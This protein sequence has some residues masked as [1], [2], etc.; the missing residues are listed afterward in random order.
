MYAD[1][2]STIF[3]GDSRYSKTVS[4]LHLTLSKLLV[5]LPDL[6]NSISHYIENSHKKSRPRFSTSFTKTTVLNV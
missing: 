3:Y 5:R 2:L 4:I 6:S 1:K